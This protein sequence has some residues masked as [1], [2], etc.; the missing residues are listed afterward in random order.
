MGI[1][2]VFRC[3]L[4]VASGVGGGTSLRVAVLDRLL[5]SGSERT[6]NQRSLFL[7]EKGEGFGPLV[8]DFNDAVGV[9]FLED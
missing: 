8:V 9:C 7:A 6:F 1:A 3:S 5:E 2:R 4:R